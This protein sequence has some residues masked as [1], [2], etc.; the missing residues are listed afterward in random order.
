M[1][2]HE[3]SVLD[4][5]E[6]SFRGD[7]RRLSPS[8]PVRVSSRRKNHKRPLGIR[9]LIVRSVPVLEQINRCFLPRQPFERLA[10]AVHMLEIRARE[11]AH[12]KQ[13][14]KAQSFILIG[15]VHSTLYF[16]SIAIPTLLPDILYTLFFRF[17]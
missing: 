12:I 13:R 2:T 11:C 7:A 6:G 4:R 1:H 10:A 9:R 8:H 16:S 5:Q 15:A 3:D 14:Q 17:V